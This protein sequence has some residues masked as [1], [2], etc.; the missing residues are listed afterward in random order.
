MVF[1][2]FLGAVIQVAVSLLIVFLV[3]LVFARK[4]GGFKTFA[5][6]FLPG[7]KGLWL[8][9]LAG[10]GLAGFNIAVFVGLGLAGLVSGEGTVAGALNGLGPGPVAAAVILMTAFVKTALAEEILFRGLLAK[11][12][13]GWLGFGL[14]NGVQAGL[15]G[16][17][18]LAL[19]LA[20]GGLEFSWLPA[21]AFFLSPAVSG[22]VFG[23][24]NELRGGG[25]IG[26]GW[27]AHGVLN[28]VSYPV[29]AFLL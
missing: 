16:A 17:I 25:S 10:L 5:G 29:F 3:Y 20:P 15:F 19:F 24:L 9:V 11:R 1:E 14:G 12:L 22:W 7:R 13:I 18:H 23:Y 27:A 21:I 28:A 6:L 4:S 2:E 8:G 26:P